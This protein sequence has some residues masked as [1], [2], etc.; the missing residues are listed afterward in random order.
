[1]TSLIALLCLLGQLA[2]GIIEFQ[3]SLLMKSLFFRQVDSC[4]CAQP[5]Y[6]SLSLL[7]QACEFKHFLRHHIDDETIQL[8]FVRDARLMKLAQI[9][10]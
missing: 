9:P 7:C 8:Q 5:A 10:C 1:M 6:A 2:V 3:D 4:V